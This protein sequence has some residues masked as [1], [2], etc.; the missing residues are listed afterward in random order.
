MNSDRKAA[1]IVGVLLLIIFALGV[2][3]FQV[4]Q[5]PTLFSDDFLTS[6]S[7]HSSEIV[8]SV[9]LLFLSGTFDVLIAIIILPILN[10]SSERL[11]Y[12]YVVSCIVGF[13]IMTVDNVSVIAMLEVSR[14]YAIA[15]SSNLESLKAIGNV[16]FQKHWWTHH[17]Y[18]LISCLPVFVLFYAMYFAKLIP[19]SVSLFGMLAAILM[20]IEMLLTILGN[21]I[22]MNLLLPI[23]LVQLVFPIWLL[24]RGF[25][26]STS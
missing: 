24:I 7:L 20:F 6:T 16:Y 19:R 17:L 18:M 23:A 25:S 26:S 9:L 10:R 4:L 22:S 1:R 2:T 11:G 15:D 13:I 12:L 5:G 21:G 3:V 8:L 14:E